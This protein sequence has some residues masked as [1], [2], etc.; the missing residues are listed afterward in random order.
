MKLAFKKI[1]SFTHWLIQWC[2][3]IPLLWN[4]SNYLFTL[5][6]MIWMSMCLAIEVKLYRKKSEGEE[7]M[8]LLSP[9]IP[10]FD[11]WLL[12]S[13]HMHMVLYPVYIDTCAMRCSHLGCCQKQGEKGKISLKF[14]NFCISMDCTEWDNVVQR[15]ASTKGPFSIVLLRAILCF[16]GT[17]NSL[18]AFGLRGVSCFKK[19]FVRTIFQKNSI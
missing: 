7:I 1:Q 5:G 11:S 15:E 10:G 13:L 17:Q 3:S 16:F 8:F 19:L 4:S 12:P 2:T 14:R 9:I 18:N 6:H